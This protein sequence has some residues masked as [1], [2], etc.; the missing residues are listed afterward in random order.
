MY[1]NNILTLYIRYSRIFR[2]LIQ[3]LFSFNVIYIYEIQHY[4]YMK[5]FSNIKLNKKFKKF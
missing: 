2:H 3:Y 1:K 5:E 4:Y